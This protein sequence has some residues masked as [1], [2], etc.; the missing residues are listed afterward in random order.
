MSLFGRIFGRKKPRTP[1]LEPI[2]PQ[3]EAPTVPNVSKNHPISPVHPNFSFVS[4]DRLSCPCCGEIILDYRFWQHMDAE[5]QLRTWWDAPLA[6]T[7]GHRC[8]GHNKA[9]GGAEKSQHLHFAT[10]NTP[11]L[12]SPRI[13][14]ITGSGDRR[15]AIALGLLAREA[16]RLGFTGIGHYDSWLHL[17][18]R[19][20]DLV[21]WD[22]RTRSV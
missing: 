10:D 21:E 16:E 12:N 6:I 14:A 20:G 4:S 19:P 15:M 7:S 9:V 3:A 13:A 18:R 11:S 1:A 5:Q 8:A 22:E 2:E 17:D